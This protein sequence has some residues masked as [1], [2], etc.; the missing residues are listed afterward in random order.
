MENDKIRFWDAVV[1]MKLISASMHAAS[2]SMAFTFYPCKI[3]SLDLC[4]F[5]QI[6]GT[7]GDLSHATQMNVGQGLV[8]L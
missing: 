8:R 2:V 4:I 1:G 7:P 5:Y 3:R 6:N